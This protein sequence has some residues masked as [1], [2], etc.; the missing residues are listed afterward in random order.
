MSSDSDCSSS[1]DGSENAIKRL[2]EFGRPFQ[3][4]N[5]RSIEACSALSRA[6]EFLPLF[7]NATLQLIEPVVIPQEPTGNIQLPT[8]TD[9]EEIWDDS[10]SDASYGVE[11]DVGLGV[12]DINGDIENSVFGSTG[13]PVIETAT[14]NQSRTVSSGDLIQEIDN[15]ENNHSSEELN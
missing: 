4:P 1:S 15:S 11:I 12:F 2:D 9:Q 7:R 10:E 14:I 8:R 5:F 6:K 3:R 13:I